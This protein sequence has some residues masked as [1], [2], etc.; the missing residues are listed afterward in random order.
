MRS[1]RFVPNR[2]W[3]LGW[4]QGTCGT[5]SILNIT[6]AGEQ[7][8]Q[9]A[10]KVAL[11]TPLGAYHAKRIPSP[12]GG[13]EKAL[14]NEL[15]KGSPRQA[16]KPL[17]QVARCALDSVPELLT[18][19]PSDQCDVIHTWKELWFPHS[20][21]NV[22]SSLIVDL[23]AYDKAPGNGIRG[24]P[25]RAQLGRTSL[26]A[27]FNQRLSYWVT[28]NKRLHSD[29]PPADDERAILFRGPAGSGKTMAMIA[30]AVHSFSANVVFYLDAAKLAR[31]SDFKREHQ[32]VFKALQQAK[33]IPGDLGM[34]SNT[35]VVFAIDNQDY[36]RHR[37]HHREWA[38]IFCE[39]LG[40]KHVGFVF[41]TATISE[42]NRNESYAVE[43]HNFGLTDDVLTRWLERVGGEKGAALLK[44]LKGPQTRIVRDVCGYL[45][46]WHTG[47]RAIQYLLNLAATQDPETFDLNP[48]VVLDGLRQ[49]LSEGNTQ[50]GPLTTYDSAH[51]ECNPL[52]ENFPKLPKSK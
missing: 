11:A 23:T 33:V 35:T 44:W 15:V 8:I 27:Y 34:G 36:L 4:H 38:Q 46:S 26:P 37:M 7:Q 49:A 20:D 31:R 16:Y 19:I 39:G 17:C 12:T 21:E 18:R 40:V 28:I 45:E 42:Q 24:M 22:A 1:L 2:G 48:S 41:A 25:L 14:Y 30:S 5:R 13:I 47:S 43:A 10:I 9:Q 6:E 51:E 50:E 29:L 3:N 52:G 32:A